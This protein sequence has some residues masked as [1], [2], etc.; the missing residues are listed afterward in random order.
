[1]DHPPTTTKQVYFIG[2][3]LL[4]NYYTNF[5][6]NVVSA[7][8]LNLAEQRTEIIGAFD[9]ISRT[10]LRVFILMSIANYNHTFTA[11]L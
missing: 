8:D 5:M 10:E 7:H 2:R 1:M 4:N 11:N 9:L 6:F 3:T